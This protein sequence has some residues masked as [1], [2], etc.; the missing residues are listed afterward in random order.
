[1]SEIMHPAF[2]PKAKPGQ[3]QYVRNMKICRARPE[4]RVSG[5]T[6]PE[7]T[8]SQ[9]SLVRELKNRQ[10]RHAL[11]SPGNTGHQVN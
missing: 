3:H 2:C 4:D 6:C 7:N 11:K 10:N 9:V 1:M 5:P 8:N